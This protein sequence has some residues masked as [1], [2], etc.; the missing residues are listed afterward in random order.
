MAPFDSL[1][2]EIGDRYCLGPNARPLVEETR[3][4][5]SR[6]PGG[7]RGFAQKCEAAGFSVEVA[8]WLK[9]SDPIPLS[10]EQAEQ[11]LG[12]EAVSR[13]AAKLG[14][15]Q[16]F[17]RTV[18]GY[19]IPGVVALRAQGGAV[20]AAI[21]GSASRLM[22]AV[23][24]ESA[25]PGKEPKQTRKTDWAD[26]E[27]VL[28]GLIIPCVTMLMIFGSLLGY[29]IGAGDRNVTRPPQ[30]AAQTEPAAPQ[31]ATASGRPPLSGKSYA[32]APVAGSGWA[33][34]ALPLPPL[35]GN[36]DSSQAG[37]RK[38][39]EPKFPVIYFAPNRASAGSASRHLLPRIAHLIRQLPK[40][41]VVEIAGYTES[42][43]RPIAN[44]KLSQRRANE[45]RGALI[46]AGAD[47]SALIAKGSGVFHTATQASENGT[48]EGR[49]TNPAE[50]RS[51]NG[52]RVEFRISQGVSSPASSP[53]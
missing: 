31:P 37:P 11:T 13:I 3:R 35:S 6:Y 43:G 29:F 32:F 28:G 30:I 17:A 22:R 12:A 51:P 14:V 26:A 52:R 47:P 16:C 4:I 7:A 15:S 45:I 24:G 27:P 23:L 48:V 25:T 20:P 40:G 18:L 50:N 44:M 2:Q 53:Q 9:G 8:S 19:A 1:V 46:R 36:N 38:F 41:T 21:R 5:I 33:L 39:S 10:G 42:A 49:S 34:P